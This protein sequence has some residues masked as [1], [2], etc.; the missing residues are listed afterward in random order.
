MDITDQ[1]L[2]ELKEDYKV[3]YDEKNK[4]WR[5]LKSG[6]VKVQNIKEVMT[7]ITGEEPTVSNTWA[8]YK[9]N[10]VVGG[11]VCICGC[12]SCKD[13]YKLFDK[14]THTCFL[15]GSDC[16]N[17]T[18]FNYS[19][20]LKCGE[21]NGFCKDC[22]I[23]LRLNGER[24]NYNKNRCD[25]TCNHC[26]DTDQRIIRQDKIQQERQREMQKQE[27][28]KVQN[29]IRMKEQK[30]RLNRIQTIFL[31]IKFE[32]KDKYRIYG[33]CWNPEKKL[34]YWTGDINDFPPKLIPL[35]RV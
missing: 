18:H 19:S 23:P 9:N 31:T 35:K 6:K 30:E 13:L 7:K 25:D 10:K 15:L 27:N 4:A 11:T 28:I 29:E 5:R 1:L 21:K 12:G 22:G 3:E 24:K 2:N 33:T 14:K 34:W 32:D 16:I 17:L 8:G 20:D 26:Y